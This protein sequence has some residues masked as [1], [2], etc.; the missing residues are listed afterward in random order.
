MVYL[1]VVFW[2]HGYLFTYSP[3]TG[4][5]ILMILTP[6]KELKPLISQSGLSCD[7]QVHKP[8]YLLDIIIACS[9]SNSSS[10]CSNLNSSFP[11]HLP[12]LSAGCITILLAI[13]S[14][15]QGVNL[16]FCCYCY[17]LSFT[18]LHNQGLSIV[19]I[20]LLDLSNPTTTVFIKVLN[21]S[22]LNY[23]IRLLSTPNPFAC[24]QINLLEIYFLY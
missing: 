21:I 15:F 20:I 22:C 11:R 3:Y 9:I 12:T 13:Q 23:H 7:T 16:S 8:N 2:P 4:S 19:P 5:T 17:S 6:T 24:L 1:T 18:A 10:T 14:R